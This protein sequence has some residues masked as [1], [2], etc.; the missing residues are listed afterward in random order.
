MAA[1]RAWTGTRGPR[2]NERSLAESIEK[3]TSNAVGQNLDRRLVDD[4]PDMPGPLVS[5]FRPRTDPG[6]SEYHLGHGSKGMNYTL[7]LETTGPFVLRSDDVTLTLSPDSQLI[8]TSDGQPY[9]LRS[10]AETDGFDP[11]EPGRIWAN[12]TTSTHEIVSVPQQGHFTITTDVIGGSRVWVDGR[13]V[14]RFEVFVYGGKNELFTW[15]QMAFVAPLEDLR[16]TGLQKLAVYGFDGQD[17]NNAS[18][19]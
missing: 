3:L 14:G 4:D 10:T 19:H 1:S 18:F 5:W 11:A 8:F 9:P 12:S 2:L 7:E 6:Q 15:S 16:G 13:F 17:D